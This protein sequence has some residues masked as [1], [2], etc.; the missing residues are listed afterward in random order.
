MANMRKLIES[1]DETLNEG[2]YGPHGRAVDAGIEKYLTQLGDEPT[3][4]EIYAARKDLVSELEDAGETGMFVNSSYIS[5]QF[6]GAVAEKL[7]LPGL[8]SNTGSS[9]VDVE[10]DDAG[11]YRSYA[12]GSRA[13]AEEL[14]QKGYLSARAAEKL[15]VTNFLGMEFGDANNDEANAVRN[16]QTMASGRRNVRRE[17]AR[18][19]ELLA[20]RNVTE[21]EGV[22]YE[23]A[24]ARL[25]TEALSPAEEAEFQ[26]L[27]AKVQ[28]LDPASY[29]DEETKTAVQ[30]AVDAA[31]AIET[32]AAQTTTEP[33]A[34]TTTTEPAATSEPASGNTDN[35]LAKFAD[36]GKGGLAN[37][38]DEVAAIKDLQ[39]RLTALGWELDVDGK[40]GPA[41]R[42]A[43]EGFQTMMGATADGDAGPETINAIVKAET[44][45]GIREFYND[46]NELIALIDKGALYTESANGER[47]EDDANISYTTPYDQFNQGA[48]RTLQNNS[49]DFRSLISLVESSLLEAVSEQEQARALEL[50]NKHKTKYVAGNTEADYMAGMPKTFQDRINKVNQWTKTNAIASTDNAGNRSADNVAVPNNQAAAPVQDG[51]PRPDQNQDQGYAANAWDAL[52][53]G[54]LDPATGK[55]I[56]GGKVPARPA[57]PTPQQLQSGSPDNTTLWDRRWAATHNPDGTPKG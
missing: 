31:K 2:K 51:E 22:V 20:K 40:Y 44:I 21:S 14:A 34:Q 30:A 11:R 35:A 53:D 55:V 8:Y 41:T 54:Y 36:S 18:F 17:V 6:I 7:E 43:V 52:Y 28:S 24:L 12:N 38:P 29:D 3:V 50:Y 42:R 5:R 4:E 49:I 56:E 57:A 25:L 37:D 10:K 9:F 27:L 47:R 45:P 48:T 46:T 33:A 23:S 15:G 26:E 32:P 13:A 19:M 16:T 1:V 39:Q